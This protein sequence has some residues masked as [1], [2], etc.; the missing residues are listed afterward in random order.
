MVQVTIASFIIAAVLL[1][2]RLLYV[3][4]VHHITAVLTH[5][6]KKHKLADERSQAPQKSIGRTIQLKRPP[7]S[8]GP[9]FRGKRQQG[10]T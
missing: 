3:C 4:I 7:V 9:S 1:H 6:Q 8:P 2:V 5:K 10:Y